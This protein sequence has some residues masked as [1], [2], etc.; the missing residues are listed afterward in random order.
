MDT[1]AIIAKWQDVCSDKHN[2]RFEG[3]AF[4]KVRPQS[5]YC[6]DTM[7]EKEVK[8]ELVDNMLERATVYQLFKNGAAHGLSYYYSKAVIPFLC[9]TDEYL[10]EKAMM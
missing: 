4:H 9:K 1:A 3:A 8:E 6:F 7:N 2:S 5:T 10:T